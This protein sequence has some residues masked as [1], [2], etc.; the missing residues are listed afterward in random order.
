M[1]QVV[2][3]NPDEADADTWSALLRAHRTQEFSERV[4]VVEGDK[5]EID[6]LRSLRGVKTPSQLDPVATARLSTIEQLM[7]R[8]WSERENAPGKLRPGE[9]LGWGHKGFQAP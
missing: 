5:P 3:V 7:I 9:G 1:E 8:A 2:I 6:A 4:F